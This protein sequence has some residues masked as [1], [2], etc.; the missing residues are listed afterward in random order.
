MGKVIYFCEQLKIFGMSLW[1]EIVLHFYILINLKAEIE[2]LIFLKQQKCGEMTSR[3]EVYFRRFTNST[4]LE[5]FKIV[6]L[7]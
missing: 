2:I 5:F 1:Y 7:L 3:K 4:F 6:L